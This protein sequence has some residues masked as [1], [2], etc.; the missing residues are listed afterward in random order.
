MGDALRGTVE[1][2]NV[3][4]AERF[5]VGGQLLTSAIRKRPRQGRIEVGA[6]GLSGDEVGDH[7]HH[8]GP[9]RALHCFAAEHY[10][11]LSVGR[12]EPPPRPWV[13]ENLTVRGYPDE[14][15]HV[16]DLVRVGTAL[17]AVSMPTERCGNPGRVAGIPELLK[18]M[19]ASLR[20]GFYFRVVEPGHI[21]AGD[22]LT[23]IERVDARWSIE[24]LSA[25]MYR[26][27]DDAERVAEV[28]AI[29]ELA[30]EWKARARILH[31]RK[32]RASGGA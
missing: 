3:G 24:R 13:G 30:P 4:R 5:E 19:I 16:G 22:A 15:A 8:G 17:L 14:R 11:A 18:E 26:E 27:I 6:L 29:P 32:R 20:T 2:V 31:A 21:G 7:E 1:L 10:D 9:N 23:L 25:V 12:G 28:E